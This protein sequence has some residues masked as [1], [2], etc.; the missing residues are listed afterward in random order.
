VQVGGV[1]YHTVEVKKNGVVLVA[2][3]YA[4]ALGLPHRSLSCLPKI[5]LTDRVTA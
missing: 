5:S 1:R 3:D 2:I 4:P